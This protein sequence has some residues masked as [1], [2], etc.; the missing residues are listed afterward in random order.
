MVKKKSKEMNKWLKLV[1]ILA[2]TFLF[3][4]AIYEW[5]VW[6][7]QNKI[8]KLTGGEEI[9]SSEIALTLLTQ[10][11]VNQAINLEGSIRPLLPQLNDKISEEDAE[12]YGYE[13]LVARLFISKQSGDLLIED[14]L[15]LFKTEEQAKN[16]LRLKSQEAKA[17]ITKSFNETILTSYSTSKGDETNPPSA[18]LRFVINNLVAKITVYGG[19]PTIDYTTPELL[20]AL[21]IP[22]ATKQKTKIEQLLKGELPGSIN[23]YE[24]NMAL[25]NFPDKLSGAELIGIVPIT[26]EEW[27]GETR[28]Q[29]ENKFTGFK[30]G[31]MGSF[32]L[33]NMPEHILNIVIMEF[34]SKED[35]L[36]EQQAFF[37]EGVH[38]EDNSS[39]A[40]EL[41]K[42]L[43]D[44]SVA[45]I[46]DT[47]AEVQSVNRVYL[48]DISIFSPYSELDKNNA[49]KNIA[50][51][52]EEIFK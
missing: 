32:K 30:S 50:K 46:S 6:D 38:L 45:R 33:S 27:L 40:L 8:K 26:K 48:Y 22:L 17:K 39:E 28:K 36:K 1:L 11:E 18:T 20:G 29:E 47:I 14:V 31:A 35:A 15:T 9:T 7:A 51:Y 41:P 2:I 23:I 37:T 52:S 13:D 16:F 24:T 12:K 34:E 4:A 19:N 21:I 49:K 25:N 5:V 42:T 10:V 43:S 44:F 3:I